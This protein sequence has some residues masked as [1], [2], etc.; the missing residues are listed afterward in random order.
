MM[1]MPTLF[2]G[3]KGFAGL[4]GDSMVFKL[5][6]AAHAAALALTGASLF[7]PS[8]MGRPMKA[9]VQV[10]LDHATQWPEFAGQALEAV[11]GGT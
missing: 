9:W 8:G 6:G 2:A 7:D 4:Y 11:R 10:P 1:G 3:G 5:D